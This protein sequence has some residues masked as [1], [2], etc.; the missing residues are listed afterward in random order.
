MNTR[1]RRALLGLTF[2]A[3]CAGSSGSSSSQE[4]LIV[5]F[6]SS[7]ETIQL[8]EAVEF[9]WTVEEDAGVTCIL[10]VD[11]NGIAD[12]EFV[13]CSGELSQTHV[14]EN[15]GSFAAELQ[16]VRGESLVD[17]ARTVVAVEGPS[18]E[19]LSPMQDAGSGTAL[20]IEARVEGA[21]AVQSI[22]AELAGSVQTLEFDD[23]SETYKGAADLT[24]FTEGS[25][26]IAFE[27]TLENAL[28][29]REE[30]GFMYDQ[31]PV[32]SV[33][34]PIFEDVAN[35]RLRVVARCDD[36]VTEDCP[37]TVLIDPQ[38]TGDFETVTSGKGSLDVRV[39]LSAFE[40]SFGILRIRANDAFQS[41][42]EDRPIY[43]ETSP[44]LFE[45]ERLPGPIRDVGS[46]RIL[47]AT[48]I[49]GS[50]GTSGSAANK[51]TLSIFDRTS[52][53]STEVPL[54][55]DYSVSPACHAFLT[56]TG[57][58]YEAL[59]PGGGQHD[60]FDFRDGALD[61]LT[62]TGGDLLESSGDFAI[63]TESG[64]GLHR[65]TF[66]TGQVD[67]IVD[68][69]DDPDL[70]ED[71]AIGW[72]FEGQLFRY[73]GAVLQL[74]NNTELEDFQPIVD[75][76]V[77]VYA[78]RRPGDEFSIAFRDGIPPSGAP[79]PLKETLLTG[80][81]AFEPSSVDDYRVRSGWLAYTDDGPTGQREPWLLFPNGT[82]SR[83]TNFP[84][85]A[86]L[87]ALNDAGEVVLSNDGERYL[88]DSGGNLLSISS[89]RGRCFYLDNSWHLA[90]GSV[91]F[92]VR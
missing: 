91:L 48:P 73:T 25:Q 58:I 88:V 69:A 70:S 79:T 43:V 82:Q 33:D 19:V 27:A 5:S 28:V 72:A 30:V 23:L 2:L 54:A 84:T 7:A 50:G 66:S 17:F 90:L 60:V 68:Q 89:D 15:G 20:A 67:F 3:S 75:R 46:D 92:E 76:D 65:R 85:T 12:Y 42:S 83:L 71:G 8:G 29:L 26:S 14:F 22:T 53:L 32:L 61:A 38:R 40:G 1:H 35:P 59:A 77:V 31:P 80:F 56:P 4:D 18:L 11:A 55:T 74:T 21:L 6:S 64:V 10:D 34:L 16:V 41:V 36:S 62:S 44:F 51:E 63:W 45:L 9:L 78:K 87:Q 13:D 81:G 57:V 47:Y 39:D 52:G 37:I 49:D 24:G 86:R